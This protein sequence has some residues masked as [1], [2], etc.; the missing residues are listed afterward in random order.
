MRHE[1]ETLKG[2]TNMR[3]SNETLKG[4]IKRKT[5]TRYIHRNA[6]KWIHEKEDTNMRHYNET[7]KGDIKGDIKRRHWKETLK[8]Y[9]LRRHG[10]EA[11][12]WDDKMGP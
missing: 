4:Y 11:R 7:L 8:L 5:L 6:L 3:H 9:I 12:K 1:N 2:D 10:H